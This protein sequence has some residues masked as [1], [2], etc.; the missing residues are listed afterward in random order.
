MKNTLKTKIGILAGCFCAVSYLAFAPIVAA[1]AQSFPDVSLSLIQMVVTLPSLMFIIFSPLSGKLMQIF[2]KR[3]LV[4]VSVG[5]TFLSG[6][7]LYAFHESFI[8]ILLGSAIMGCGSGLLMPTVNALICEYF[9]GQQRGAMMGL[10]ATVVALGGLSFTF[11]SG[12]LARTGWGSSFLVFFLT[13]PVFALVWFCLP[14]SAAK[15]AENAERKGGFELTPMVMALFIIGFV[16]FCLQ[17]AFNTNA[18]VYVEELALGD[19]GMAGLVSMMSPLGGIIGGVLFGLL[20]SKL[21]K[22][23]ETAALL[24][25]GIGF[26][27]AGFIPSLGA[28]LGGGLLVGIAYALF[29]AAGTLLLSMKVR[30]ENNDFTAAVYLAFVNLGAALSPYAVNSLSAPFG[31]AA[32]VRFMLCGV[33]ITVCAAASALLWKKSK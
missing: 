30:P 21:G 15:Q 11:L 25:A 16:Y 33:L 12:Q 19:A 20:A 18:S 31:S 23:I 24:S 6:M 32:G 26:L 22:Q 13:V 7:V 27:I 5:L 14:K 1:I 2:P 17:N 3:T 9:D 10:N 4:L 28:V 29:N 8:F